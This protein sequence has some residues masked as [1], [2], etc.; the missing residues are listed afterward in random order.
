MSGRGSA[1]GER[2]GGRGIGVPNKRTP[3]LKAA[4]DSALKEALTGGETPLEVIIAVMRG[5]TEITDRQFNAACA[6]APYVHSRLTSATIEHRDAISELTIEQ[7]RSFVDAAERHN[8]ENAGDAG[9]SGDSEAGSGAV[10]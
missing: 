8:A 1:P 6:A 2:R 5:T 3:E 4:R 7:L 10:H 9:E